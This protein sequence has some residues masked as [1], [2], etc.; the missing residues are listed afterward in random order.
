[1]KVLVI[2]NCAIDR[3]FLVPHLPAAG[4]TMLADGGAVDVGGKGANQA[5]AA[6]RAGAPVVL[7]SAVGRDADGARIKS[8]LRAEGVAVGGVLERDG[9]TDQSIILVADC[10]ENC[11]VSSHEMAGSIR[12][13]DVATSL[14]SL[15]P[16]DILLMQGNL[17]R[18][19]TEQCLGDGRRRAARVMLNPAP[20][21]YPYDEVWGLVDIV[22][23]NEVESRMLSGHQDPMAGARALLRRGPTLVV[24]T[25]GSMGAVLVGRDREDRFPASRVAVVDTTGAGDVFCGVFAA[26]LA[27]ELPT[28][29]AASWAV[30]AATLSVTRRGTQRA[31]PTREELE[32]SRPVDPPG[33]VF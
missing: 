1:V 20:I 25:L 27:L 7:C 18:R 3:S 29:R 9:P 13:E 6:A 10:G 21:S 23:M 31:F 11:I 15:A 5:V 19:T 17:S 33:G 12:P 26:G 22:V 8:I 16:G 24:V 32:A 30:Q 4:E 14:T 2:G 28:G